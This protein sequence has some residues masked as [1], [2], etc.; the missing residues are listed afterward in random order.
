MPRPGLAFMPYWRLSSFYFFYFASLGALVPFWG[1]YLRDRGFTALDI[2]QLMAILMATKIVAPNVWGWIADHTGRR[3]GIVRLASLLSVSVFFGVFYADGFWALALVMT[4]FSFF[5]NASI[6]QM[7]AVTF[8]HLGS[9]VQRYSTIRLWGSIGFIVTVAGLGQALEWNDTG[10]VPQVVLMLYLGIWLSSLLV[11]ESVHDHPDD[12]AG[13]IWGLLKRPE[14]MAFFFA[15]FMQQASHGAYYAFYSIYL[16]DH[17]YSKTLI[18]GL[19]AL[20][21]V[22]EVLV[23]LWMH[24]LLPRFGARRVLIAS[25]GLA[26]LRWLT[27]GAFPDQL[28]VLLFAQLLHAATFGT[29]HASSIHLVH[30]YFTGRFQVRGQGLYSSLSYGAGGALGAL[31]SGYLWS[32]A[33][34]FATFSVASAMALLGTLAAWVWVDRGHRY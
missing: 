12:H 27:I 14:V 9:R 28:W 10:L 22:I 23:F 1:L 26:V 30:H 15:C 25:L 13:H 18:G 11:P 19:W 29:F 20:G 4:L 32:D 34:A 33:G 17:G 24:R 31:V 8:N 6:P 7:E 2:G 16:Q 3:V 5:W 21:V